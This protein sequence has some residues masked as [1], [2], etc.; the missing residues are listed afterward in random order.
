MTSG[1]APA[2]PRTSKGS[3]TRDRVLAVARRALADEG[4]EG[5]VL[6]SVAESA[7]LALGNLQYYFPT[8]AALVEAVVL[9]ESDEDLRAVDDAVAGGPGDATDALGA[10]AAALLD[11]WHG[12]AHRIYVSAGAMA[13]TEPS[14]AAVLD[15]VWRR[16]HDA[17][18]DV[19]RAIDPAA[20]DDEVR[21]RSLAVTAL[22]DGSSLQRPASLGV[23]AQAFRSR[24]EREVVRI[25]RGD[26]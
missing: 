16:F 4:A 24:I 12:D 5:F 15:D 18:A 3:A 11:R 23:D 17:V 20:P 9:A 7:G 8:R 26:A 1:Y 19:V 13:M 10:M 14:L 2:V 22:L 21:V 6:R 25:S